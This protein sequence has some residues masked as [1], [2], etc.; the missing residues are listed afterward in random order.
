MTGMLDAVYRERA[1]LL[2]H[3]A[4]VYPSH[5][6]PDMEE[7]DWPVLYI[8]FPTGQCCWHVND[9]DLD[10]FG[11]VPVDVYEVWD[12]HST[13]EK[14]ERVDTATR[15]RAAQ[16]TDRMQQGLDLSARNPAVRQIHRFFAYDQLPAE[17]QPVSR[18]FAITADLMLQWLPDSPELTACLRKLL[19]AKDCAVRAA[20]DSNAT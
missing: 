10:L 13:A 4:A 6:Q 8:E 15:I 9:T 5:I 7:P 12:G 20:L 1:H 16:R 18:H 2:A 3:L 14:Y 11:H 17:L 19:E